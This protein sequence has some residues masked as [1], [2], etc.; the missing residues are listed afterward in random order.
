MRN[1]PAQDFEQIIIRSYDV[2]WKL[3]NKD[4]NGLTK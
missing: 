1:I 3:Q 2:A 4:K